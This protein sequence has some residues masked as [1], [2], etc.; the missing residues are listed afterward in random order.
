MRE[1]GVDDPEKRFF[2][3]V[4]RPH[5]G[6]REDFETLALADLLE[7]GE[8]VG[9]PEPI[10]LDLLAGR[11]EILA[12]G[13]HLAA[14]LGEIFEHL[15]DFP[16]GLTESHHDPRLADH[17]GRGFGDPSDNFHGPLVTTRSADLVIEPRYGLDVVVVNLRPGLDDPVHSNE[18]GA[19]I[20]GQDLDGR[21][22]VEL[23][24]SSDRLDKTGGAPVRQIVTIN[25]GDDHVLEIHP[26]YRFSELLRLD[27]AGRVLANEIRLTLG[28]AIERFIEKGRL[29]LGICNGF[30]VLVKTG[31]LPGPLTDQPKLTLAA[32]DSGRFECRWVYLK[33]NPEIAA[34][35]EAQIRAKLLPDTVASDNAPDKEEAVAKEA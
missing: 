24:Q 1:S 21:R 32:N 4:R 12:D 14:G 2:G 8:L 30:Q 31:I 22:R 33:A 19:E 25:S 23:A 15:D 34:D 18:V 7:L 20:R 9:R 26:L 6:P 17:P 10:D 29:I 3:S 27:P 13:H 16:L 35:I 28:A 5:E 11:L